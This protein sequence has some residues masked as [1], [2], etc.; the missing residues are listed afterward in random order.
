MYDGVPNS[1][2]QN[3]I[4]TCSPDEE[5][6]SLTEGLVRSSSAASSNSFDSCSD[7]L[8]SLE[9]TEERPDDSLVP[10]QLNFRERGS[11]F[12]ENDDGEFS[13][14]S[15]QSED[16]LVD[17]ASKRDL[18]VEKKDIA[19]SSDAEVNGEAEQSESAIRKDHAYGLSNAILFGKVKSLAGSTVERISQ[20]QNFLPTNYIFPLKNVLHTNS[21]FVGTDLV[22]QGDTS[23]DIS[24]LCQ[25]DLEDAFDAKPADVNV[26]MERTTVLPKES[27]DV[28]TV[29]SRDMTGETRKSEGRPIKKESDG[30]LHENESNEEKRSVNDHDGSCLNATMFCST[31][32]SI[33]DD[34]AV[35]NALGGSTLPP[36]DENNLPCNMSS[37]DCQVTLSYIN[38]SDDTIMTTMNASST[39]A[40]ISKHFSQSDI[41]T[42]KQSSVLIHPLRT[43]SSGSG[44]P[45]LEAVDDEEDLSMNIENFTDHTLSTANAGNTEGGM[46]RKGFS[47]D[48]PEITQLS[49]GTFRGTEQNMDGDQKNHRDNL[50]LSQ[51]EQQYMGSS[52]ESFP[53]PK[54][55]Y[56]WCDQRSLPEPLK[57][58][59]L[60]QEENSFMEEPSVEGILH[61]ERWKGLRVQ[62]NSSLVARDREQEENSGPDELSKY[63]E[64]LELNETYADTILDMED[65]LLNSDENGSR[66]RFFM[67]SSSSII[68]TPRSSRDGSVGSSTSGLLLHGTGEPIPF[69]VDWVEVI[70]AKQRRGGASLGERIVGVKDHTVY[71]IKVS[72]GSQEW[73]VL[74]R[75]RDFVDLYHQLRRKFNARTGKSLPSLWL[76]V[77]RDSRKVFG[78]TFPNIVE[79]RSNRIERCLQSLL[80]AG[81][82]FST[83]SPL[84]WFLCPKD[85][86]NGSRYLPSFEVLQKG[87]DGQL[88]PIGS[89]YLLSPRSEIESQKGDLDHDKALFSLGKTVKLNLKI[90]PNKNLKQLLASQHHSCAGCYKHL[91]VERGLMH[92]F[93]QTLGWGKPRLCEYSGQL[94]CTSCHLN[95]TAVLPAQVLWHWDFTPRRVSQ[96]AKA[97]LDS[98]YDQP[99]LCVSAVNPHLYSRVP[100]LSHVKETRRKLSK[101]IACMLCPTRARILQ[102]MASRRYLLESND[103][104][105][106]R[107]LEDLSKGAFA[108]LPSILKAVLENLRLHVMKQCSVCSETGK[109]C[110]AGVF[111][112]EPFSP[113]FPFE[114]ENI[115]SCKICHALFHKACFSKFASCTICEKDKNDKSILHRGSDHLQAEDL[116]ES[117]GEETA[118]SG[119]TDAERRFDISCSIP[120]MEIT[121]PNL[122]KVDSH[123]G[124]ELDN[125]PQTHKSWP[126]LYS[127]LPKKRLW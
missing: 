109:W 15:S 73:D 45:D 48:I 56:T 117:H 4:H 29:L 88:G 105:A 72:S 52:T 91:D 5:R 26:L 98:I 116:N 119:G 64:N 28:V 66:E 108:A 3:D 44:R 49:A 68:G 70:G 11:S 41:S 57:D 122:A 77:E 17:N 94:Y 111:C 18:S 69:T 9:N 14:P 104:F 103:F 30:M 37:S 42:C 31:V 59:K 127:F 76:E 55:E 65:V 80:E 79:I 46:H 35:N 47:L 43:L 58:L 107:D 82:P 20:L 19:H 32:S 78:N 67:P 120:E 74:R 6:E 113:I 12:A 102:T 97:Y 124:F 7:L 22:A 24:S 89:P 27:I 87:H 92:G 99:M 62:L 86:L 84:C 13:H 34:A 112:E 36:E 101:V 121:S 115:T 106:L 21:T 75:Y 90:H 71:C 53:S 40:N 81:P 10:T 95:E 8:G 2:E 126:Y 63:L 100:I 39:D 1:D 50:L 83:C 114:E 60:N 110:D 118:N 125:H 85:G 25:N 93:V 38:G 33:E 61:D 16:I 51:T 96:L 23:S 54:N 123:G